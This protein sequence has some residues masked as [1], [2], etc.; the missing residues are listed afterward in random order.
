MS[1]AIPESLRISSSQTLGEKRSPRLRE[2]LNTDPKLVR[3]FPAHMLFCKIISPL[4]KAAFHG[5]ISMSKT[6]NCWGLAQLRL[7]QALNKALEK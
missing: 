1:V 5:L 6:Y 4:F 2:K 3:N 7:Q